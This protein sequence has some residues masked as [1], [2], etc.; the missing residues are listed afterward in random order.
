MPMSQTMK[1]ITTIL[2]FVGVAALVLLIVKRFG[3]ETEGI[4][5]T[6]VTMISEWV[7]RAVPSV[8]VGGP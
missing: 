4:A 6:L 2:I 7:D 8:P 3:G 1:Y 5:N